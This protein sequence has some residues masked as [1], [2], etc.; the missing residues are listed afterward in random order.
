MC[1]FSRRVSNGWVFGRGRT[2]GVWC[3][4]GFGFLFHKLQGRKTNYAEKNNITKTFMCLIL[5]LV[6]NQYDFYHVTS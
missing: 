6:L 1:Y 3:L 2:L 5:N 4:V